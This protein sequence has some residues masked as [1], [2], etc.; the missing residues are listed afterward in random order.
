MYNFN[1]FENQGPSKEALIS[2]NKS[3]E[4]TFSSAFC[5][6]NKIFNY[7]FVVLFWDSKKRAIG[8]HFTNNKEEKG[9][10]ALA[11]LSKGGGARVS[12]KGFLNNSKIDASIYANRYMWKKYEDEAIG[13]LYVFELESK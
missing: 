9:R 1:R 11:R 6:M 12:A 3:N 10:Y 4:I 8:I 2:I 13:T 5:N 7:A